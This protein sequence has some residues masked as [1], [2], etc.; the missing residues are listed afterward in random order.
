MF[1]QI[2]NAFLL[3]FAFR[4][5]GLSA[6]FNSCGDYYIEYKVLISFNLKTLKKILEIAVKPNKFTLVNLFLILVTL[7]AQI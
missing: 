3:D 1:S 2:A 7:V 5:N 4:F 6:S